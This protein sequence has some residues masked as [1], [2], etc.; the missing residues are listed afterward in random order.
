VAFAPFSSSPLSSPFHLTLILYS[1]AG[2]FALTIASQ[3]DLW[4]LTKYSGNA[5]LIL[6]GRKL[7]SVLF[8]AL[9]LLT[10]A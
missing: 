2:D 4:D 3:A 7:A 6:L 5:K 10:Y 1:L 8:A 9:L